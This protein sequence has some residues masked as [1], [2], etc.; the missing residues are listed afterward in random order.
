VVEE[1]YPSS[2][3]AMIQAKQKKKNSKIK[4]LSLKHHTQYEIL[5]NQFS[6]RKPMWGIKQKLQIEMKCPKSYLQS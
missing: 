6:Y 3:A 4:S 5:E 1:L 2:Y